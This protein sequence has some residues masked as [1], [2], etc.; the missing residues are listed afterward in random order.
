MARADH[1]DVPLDLSVGLGN[2]RGRKAFRPSG[3]GWCLERLAAGV[4]QHVA[5]RAP[6]PSRHRRLLLPQFGCVAGVL[7]RGLDRRLEHAFEISGP[8]GCP[9]SNAAR[10]AGCHGTL[11]LASK[12][13]AVGRRPRRAE[14]DTGSCGSR[15]TRDA[16]G[17]A[18]LV[19][20]RG[21]NGWVRLF[22][23]SDQPPIPCVSSVGGMRAP[24]FGTTLSNNSMQRSALRV[25]LA[26]H[27]ACVRTIRTNPPLC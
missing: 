2:S 9:R 23:P 13:S 11:V 14:R 12:R 22:S 15:S 26:R 17:E 20:R 5:V 7:I 6:F 21:R 19:A 8:A 27:A 25:G 3:A 1:P 10:H 16:V 18:R 24:L 4:A